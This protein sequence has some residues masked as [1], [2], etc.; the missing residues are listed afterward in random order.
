MFILQAECDLRVAQ[1]E[2]DRQAEITKLLL[3]GISTSQSIHLR[4]LH[5]F[6]EAQVKNIVHTLLR[7]CCFK[8][9]QYI[10]IQISIQVR[11]YGQCASAMDDLQRELARCVSI[12]F[13]K[14]TL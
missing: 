7:S 4:H 5:A 9:I 6:V 3:E 14:K 8:V 11:Y 1:S 13:K 10:F 2:F 12:H